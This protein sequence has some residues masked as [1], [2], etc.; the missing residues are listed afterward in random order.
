MYVYILW[1]ADTTAGLHVQGFH[2]GKAYTRKWEGT[3]R[4]LGTCQ[5]SLEV[6]RTGKGE[7]WAEA[8]WTAKKSLVRPVQSP[9]ILES[10]QR[11][12]AHASVSLSLSHWLREI[13]GKHGLGA[14][15]AL[16]LRTEQLGLSV[17]YFPAVRDLTGVFSK[18]SQKPIPGAGVLK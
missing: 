9:C 5:I 7:S 12:T 17:N 11:N 8:P 6:W 2:W 14:N 10:Y 16:D 15:T 18:P 3:R 1:A 4:S 13:Y